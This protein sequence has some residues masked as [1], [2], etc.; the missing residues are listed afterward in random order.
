VKDLK[1]MLLFDLVY[2]RFLQ[3]ILQCRP[4]KLE[5]EEARPVD[6][7]GEEK[8]SARRTGVGQNGRSGLAYCQ[9]PSFQVGK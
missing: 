4:E 9:I 2:N 7:F 8:D 5:E 3:I 6:R 1:R